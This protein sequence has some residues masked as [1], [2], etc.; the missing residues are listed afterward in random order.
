MIKIWKH[1]LSSIVSTLSRDLITLLGQISLTPLFLIR[2]GQAEYTKWLTMLSYSSFIVLADFGMST[3]IIYK[4]INTFEKYRFYDL[5]LWNWFKKKTLLISFFL[6]TIAALVCSQKYPFGI[7][8]LYLFNS[9]IQLFIALT[10]SAIITLYQ[11]FW[12]YKKQI[13]DRTSLGQRHISLLRFFEI[14]SLIILLQFDIQLTNF[15][16]YFAFSKLFF[17]LSLQVSQRNKSK[18]FKIPG[19]NSD[20][21]GIIKPIIGNAF[22]TTADV[23]SLHGSFILASFWLSPS[24][25][26]TIAIAR[27]LA[28]PVRILATGIISSS[29]PFLIRNN[30]KRNQESSELLALKTLANWS[31]IVLAAG[32]LILL[33]LSKPLWDFLSHNMIS[34]NGNIVLWFCIAT[35][36]DSFLAFKFQRYI[37]TNKALYGGIVYLSTT[38]FMTAFQKMLGNYVGL[39]AVPICIFLADI[40]TITYISLRESIDA[41]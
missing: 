23:V 37:S 19:A 3:V 17:F 5:F 26:I 27:M 39:A 14:L 20:I 28:S 18:L 6:I 12:L 41:V 13:E 33:G 31:K 30:Q 24:E 35:L 36:S 10:A 2:F 9:N 15:A 8:K 4:L 16:W 25:L 32:T 29:L 22:I 40:I 21:S 38:L 7:Q 11:H 1:L 34:Y